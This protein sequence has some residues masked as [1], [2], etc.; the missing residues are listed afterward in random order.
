MGRVLK[1]IPGSVE[2]GL[3]YFWGQQMVLWGCHQFPLWHTGIAFGPWYRADVPILMGRAHQQDGNGGNFSTAW[4]ALRDS[5]QEQVGFSSSQGSKEERFP[6]EAPPL[7]GWLAGPSALCR[8]CLLQANF[9]QAA[10][11]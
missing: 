8:N 5:V 9:C 10:L 3:N 11:P 1:A 6:S 7:L 2:K 4:L